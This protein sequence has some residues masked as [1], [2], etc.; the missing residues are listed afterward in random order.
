MH[1]AFV[2]AAGFGT[3]LRPLTT[4]KPKPLVPVCGVPML[5]YALALCARHG[6]SPVVVNAHHLADQLR[7]WA[8]SHE[9]VDVTIS[10][11]LPDILGTGGG[12]RKVRD[13]LAET[14]AV[15]NGDT[16]CNVDLRALLD[17]IPGGGGAMALRV[18]P[19]DARERYGVV[20]YDDAGLVTDLK[21]MARST[22]EGAEHRDA[23]F[24]GIHALHRDM[25]DHVPEGMACIVR[26]A[27]IAEVPRRRV[28]A[29]RHD[30]T[31]LDVGDPAAYLDTNLAVLGGAVSLPLDPWSRAA[32]GTVTGS[33]A[34]AQ[35]GRLHG[36]VWVGEGARIQGEVV[37]SAI[38]ARAVVPAGAR[39]DSCI[40]WDDVVV[41]PGAWYRHV[42]A[43]GDPVDV[44]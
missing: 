16:L 14:V 20:A 9:G 13:Q 8:G 37:Q 26:T 42:F 38:G 44:E 7:P 23:H 12:L 36:P 31:W 29:V 15:V 6:L 1:Q 30:G 32:G 35:G 41:P 11:E 17:A 21:R 22:P 2:L 28:A 5:S 19:E 25:L 43:G 39:L 33:V 24:T 18:H 3:R 4:L 10:E 27:Y 34:T 40:V